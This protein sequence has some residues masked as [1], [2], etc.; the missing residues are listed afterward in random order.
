MF[1][2]QIIGLFALVLTT[3]ALAFVDPT[4]PL[5]GGQLVESAGSVQ[6]QDELV[7]QSI[8]KTSREGSLK[9]IISGQLV[10]KGMTVLGYRV[11]DIE[12]KRV[13]LQS[14]ENTRELSLFA[15]SVVKY[16]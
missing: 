5:T 10:E 12:G 14:A 9:A 11:V 4:R 6:P 3:N 7:L 16:K 13:T 15:D 8:L 2:K 1:S